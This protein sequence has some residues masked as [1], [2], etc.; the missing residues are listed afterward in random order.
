MGEAPA[1]T[2]AQ[3]VRRLRLDRGLAQEELARQ[4][5]VSKTQVY[6]VENGLTKNPRPERLRRYARALGVTPEY[7][8]EGRG[9][10]RPQAEGE[11]PPLEVCLRH[12]SRLNEAEIAQIVR[13]VRALEAEQE[14]ELA[15]RRKSSPGPK[16]TPPRG[17]EERR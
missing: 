8:R 16:R 17:R 11:L 1:E 5:G 3:R 4:V 7:L 6:L 13:I 12:T 10:E 9:P 15:E 14:R 2:L